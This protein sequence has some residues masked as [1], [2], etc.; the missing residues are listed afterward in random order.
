MLKKIRGSEFNRHVLA[1]LSGSTLA[2]LIP[3]ISEPFLVRFF[4]PTEFGILALFLAVATLFSSVATAR[5][6][7]AIVLPKKDNI[8]INILALS[9]LITLFMSLLSGLVV[10][11]FKTQIAALTQSPDLIYFLKWVPLYVLLAGIFQSFNQWATRKKYFNSVAIS[12]MSQ[13]S[14]N[15]GV[16]LATGWIGWNA[17]GLIWGQISGWF[18]ASIALIYRFNEKDRK[19]ISARGS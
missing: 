7:M 14:T 5:Y 17:L 18:A 4:T 10:Y 2:Q 11:F 13:S 3:L 12:K 1:I 9:L 19:L 6:E 15:A 8:A 16:S